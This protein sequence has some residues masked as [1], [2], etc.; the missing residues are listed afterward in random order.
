MA[1]RFDLACP[2][3]SATTA[4][5][6]R[7]AGETITCWSCREPFEIP[8]LRG[9]RQLNPAPLATAEQRQPSTSPPVLSRATF[10]AGFLATVVGLVAGAAL[11]FS[12]AQLRTQPPAADIAKFNA[13]LFSRIDRQSLPEFW[14]TWNED[15]IGHPPGQWRESTFAFNRQQVRSRHLLGNIF[16]GVAA[17]G[18]ATMIGSRFIRG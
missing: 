6:S 1:D 7:Q 13:Q 18:L 16:F 17:L 15:V 2:R 5:E 4:V 10:A 9:L 3:C 12:A 14:Q 8:T 11:Y